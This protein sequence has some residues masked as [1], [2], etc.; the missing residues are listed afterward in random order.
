[1]A[2]LF[3]NGDGIGSNSIADIAGIVLYPEFEDSLLHRILSMTTEGQEVDIV[4]IYFE[5]AIGIFC[6][7]NIGELKFQGIYIAGVGATAVGNFLYAQRLRKIAFF[8]AEFKYELQASVK[9]YK[10]GG[11]TF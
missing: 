7:G 8:V 3:H 4:E 10:I 5:L 11:N 9:G 6:A 1:M 2:G